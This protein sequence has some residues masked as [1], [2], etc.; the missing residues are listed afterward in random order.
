M[1]NLAKQKNQQVLDHQQPHP[2]K[3]CKHKVIHVNEWV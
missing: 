2:Q 1:S 3:P